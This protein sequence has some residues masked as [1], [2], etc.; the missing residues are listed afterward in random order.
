M[1]G[2]VRTRRLEQKIKEWGGIEL[3]YERHESGEDI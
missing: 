3:L 2:N 1:P